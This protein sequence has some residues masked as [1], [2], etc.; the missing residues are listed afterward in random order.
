M[1]NNFRERLEKIFADNSLSEY[2]SDETAERFE[3]LADAMINAKLNITAIKD[4]DS[5]ILRHFADSLTIAKYI[6]EGVRVADIGCGGGFP[7]FPL[8]IARPDLSV[9]GFDSTAKKINYINETSVRLGLR[10]LRG[11]SLRVE[12]GAH[13][14]VFRE[15]FDFVTARAVASL[16]TLTEYCLPYVKVGGVFG[17]MKSKTGAD[18]LDASAKAISLLGGK[19]NKSLEIELVSDFEEENLYRNIILID[20]VKNTPKNYPRNNSQISKKPL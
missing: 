8:A 4:N 2:I 12:E 13:D 1:P 20:K 9:V 18:E 14:D 6:P 16:P 17:A 7:S 15:S 11:V 19:V 5:I 10:N 3:Q